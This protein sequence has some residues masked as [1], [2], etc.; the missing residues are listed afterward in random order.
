M[1][2]IVYMNN[3]EDCNYA[4]PETILQRCEEYKTVKKQKEQLSA[5]LLK[6]TKFFERAIK[7]NCE[8]SGIRFTL[9]EQ[10]KVEWKK[11]FEDK[12]T[13]TDKDIKE[14][15]TKTVK[16]LKIKELS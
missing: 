12:L 14:A 6:I 13:Q 3:F 1:I 11:M 10:K 9:E 5:K 15:Y 2:E 16:K 7:E 4:D 8:I